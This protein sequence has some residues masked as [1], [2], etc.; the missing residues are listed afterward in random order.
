MAPI[1]TTTV[2]RT[3]TALILTAQATIVTHTG[4]PTMAGT[5][6]RTRRLIT[7]I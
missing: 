7:I 4:T 3:N 6:V 1:H 5:K 2:H